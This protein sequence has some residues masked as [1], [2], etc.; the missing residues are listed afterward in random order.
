MGLQ[1]FRCNDFEDVN[2]VKVW[3]ARWMGGDTVSKLEGCPT[4]FGPRTVYATNH[5]DTFFTI[6]A[7]CRYKGK[8][9]R[10]YLTCKDGHWEFNAY[11]RNYWFPHVTEAE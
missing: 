10:G 6:P 5:P 7:A 4:P 11:A 3:F 8:D 9:V 1:K 2:G